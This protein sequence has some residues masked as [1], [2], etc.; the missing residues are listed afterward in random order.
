MGRRVNQLTFRR[1]RAKFSKN[2]PKDRQK[3]MIAQ[4]D[5]QRGRPFNLL[6]FL[7]QPVPIKL[8]F[9]NL[10]TAGLLAWIGSAPKPAD[11]QPDVLVLIGHTKEHIDDRRFE[12]LLAALSRKPE[13]RIISFDDLAQLLLKNSANEYCKTDRQPAARAGTAY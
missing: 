12:E 8:D 4:L 10:S 6:R 5:L 11:G 1:L 3:E 13:L 9:H 2:V 7:W